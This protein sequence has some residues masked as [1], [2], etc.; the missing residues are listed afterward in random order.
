MSERAVGQPLP[1]KAAEILASLAAHRV[2]S[3]P[4]VFAIH[5]GGAELRWV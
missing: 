3:T 1:A 2:L 4:Q 5:S